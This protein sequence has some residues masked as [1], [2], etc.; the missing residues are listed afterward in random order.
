M[1]T[2]GH[3]DGYGST[4]PVQNPIQPRVGVFSE[5]ALRRYDY[6]M[7]AL[8]KVRSEPTTIGFLGPLIRG[9]CSLNPTTLAVNT[10]SEARLGLAAASGR[11]QRR[12]VPPPLPTPRERLLLPRSGECPRL[13]SCNQ[14]NLGCLLI[15][16]ATNKA[17]A[18]LASPCW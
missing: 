13:R 10:L 3:N 11:A 18:D 1:R 5:A 8:S 16:F 15:G 2:F 7:D 6:V 17:R 4:M 9:V 12:G 14:P